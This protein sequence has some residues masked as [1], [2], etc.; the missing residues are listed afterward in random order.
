MRQLSERGFWLAYGCLA[1]IMSWLFFGNHY[2]PA[3]DLPQHAAQLAVWVHYEEPA[4][5]FAEQFELNWFTPYLLGYVMAR[6]LVPLLGLG[7]PAPVEAF[8]K[9]LGGAASPCALVALGLFLAERRGAERGA[10]SRH[11]IMWLAGLKLVV[12][13][14]VDLNCGRTAFLE[15][16]RPD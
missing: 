13:D 9:L 2:L 8:L 7:V 5:R 4:Y 6:P 16:H 10:R 1:L 11:T 15:R 3:T 12:G 14:A